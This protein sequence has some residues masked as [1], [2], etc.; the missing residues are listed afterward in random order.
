MKFSWTWLN[1]IIDLSNFNLEEVTEKLTL[2][3]FEIDSIKN[4]P[5]I[6]DKIIDFSVTANRQDVNCIIGLAREI[7]S[8]MNIPFKHNAGRN[9]Y[10]KTHKNNNIESDSLEDLFIDNLKN[11]KNTASPKWLQKYLAG[12]SITISNIIFDDIKEYIKIKW[13]QE[14]QI[15]DSNKIQLKHLRASLFS[16]GQ[17]L[18]YITEVNNSK[19]ELKKNSESMEHK[20]KITENS[21]IKS[22]NDIQYDNKTSSITLVGKVYSEKY[23]KLLK[24]NIKPKHT[25]KNLQICNRNDLYYAYC[26]ALEILRTSTKGVHGKSYIYRKKKRDDEIIY[27]NKKNIRQILG[28]I[29]KR[30][31]NFLATNEIIRILERLNLKPQY[32]KATQKFQVH[33][34]EHRIEDLK[35]PIDV[36]EEI[37]RIHGFNKFFD[38]LPN[39]I[40]K[41]RISEIKNILKKIRQILRDMGLNE[42]I[43]YSLNKEK[44]AD[45]ISIYN[46]LIKDQAVLQNNIYSSLIDT[47]KYNVDQK[48]FQTEIFEIGRIFVHND[49]NQLKH[50]EYIHLAGLIG[51][52][53]FSR[54]CWSKK[55][56]ELSWFEAKGMIEDFFEKLTADIAWKPFNKKNNSWFKCE[57]LKIINEKKSAHIYNKVTKEIIGIFAELSSCDYNLDCK[58]Y[59]F[60]I[61]VN[62][63]RKSLKSLTH[64]DYIFKK[65]STYPSITRDIS[66]T[67]SSKEYIDEIKQK[68]FN[69]NR[70]IKSVNIFNEYK[71]NN[72]LNNRNVGLRIIYRSDTK[73]LEEREV[74]EI[75]QEINELLK[76]YIR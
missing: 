39:T 55:S 73:T 7:S 23:L 2:A 14:I 65:Y 31:R 5:E 72:N 61:N 37:A 76:E 56:N 50:Q 46:P 3:G 49:F 17:N 62:L 66:L 59:I 60:E 45:K 1:E 51:K 41:G 8:I 52:K 53:D 63:L 11:T 27:V 6:Q 24:S 54:S 25:I 19:I 4:L 58:T 67:L 26:E 32:N 34:P 64:L 48:N 29:K 15:F 69:Q 16:I 68:I 71:N 47:K 40:K 20:N 74:A 35:R 75:N 33:I 38:S 9:Y 43:H 12:C 36:I 28:Q 42:T 57:S 18:S 70:L 13:G 30:R 22:N 21:V 10:R 44:R